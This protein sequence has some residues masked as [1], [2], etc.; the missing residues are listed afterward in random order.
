MNKLCDDRGDPYE[1]AKLSPA[2]YEELAP[3]LNRT[4]ANLFFNVERVLSDHRG[5]GVVLVGGI[6]GYLLWHLMISP[7]SVPVVGSI[8]DGLLSTL[9]AIF[10]ALGLLHLLYGWVLRGRYGL[11]ETVFLEHGYCVSCGYSLVD[12]AKE[13]DGCVVCPECNAAWSHDR[14]G[15][16]S[17]S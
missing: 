13:S 5:A 4:T 16:Q 9:F 14:I 2:Q 12:L 6:A 17:E 3:K 15:S 11:V 7:Y 1:I 8:I 10:L